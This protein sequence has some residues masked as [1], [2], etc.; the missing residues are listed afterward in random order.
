M[1]FNDR[2]R[3]DFEYSSDDEGRYRFLDRVDDPFFAQVREVLN[4]WAARY[5]TEALP[6]LR[7]R[8]LG[9]DPIDAEAAGWELMVHELFVRDGWTAQ[10][11]TATEG[12]TRPDFRMTR[13]GEVVVVEARLVTGVSRA[14]QLK[15]RRRNAMYDTLDDV[16]AERFSLRVEVLQDGPHGPPRKALLRR[17]EAWLNSLDP[18]LVADRLEAAGGFHGATSAEFSQSGWRLEVTALPLKTDRPAR[19]R[20]SRAVGVRGAETWVGSPTDATRRALKRKGSRYRGLGCPLVIAIA[21]DQLTFRLDDMTEALFG[22]DAVSDGTSLTQ[23]PSN[24]SGAYWSPTRGRRVSSVLVAV[25]PRPWS[26]T[27]LALRQ[28]DNP[29]AQHPF[30]A[31]V[32]WPRLAFSNQSKRFVTFEGAAPSDLFGVPNVWPVGEPFPDEDLRS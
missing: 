19:R 22:F 15:S 18:D 10:V 8:L 14:D 21:Q 17:I 16:R 6:A 1:L 5:P 29:W 27:S 9:T 2:T 32:P 11:E 28:V 25:A 3:T 13:G 24:G 7:A 30:A 20:R 12:G 26:L 4:G 23:L 31:D